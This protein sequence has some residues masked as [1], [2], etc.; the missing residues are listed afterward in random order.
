MKT[1]KNMTFTLLVFCAMLIA[2]AAQ[3]PSPQVNLI[4]EREGIRFDRSGAA[5]GWQLEV[6]N[7]TGELVFASGVMRTPSLTWTL[8]DQQGQALASGLYSYRLRMQ[9]ETGDVLATQTGNVMVN[10]A[11]ENDRIW[12]T[13]NRKAGVGAQDAT[14]LTVISADE[15]ALGGAQLARETVTSRKT[16]TNRTTQDSKSSGVAVPEAVGP[17]SGEGTIGRIARF[18]GANAIGDSAIT[19]SGGNIRINTNVTQGKLSVVNADS[20]AIHGQSTNSFGI[21]GNSTTSIGVRGQSNSGQ[22]VYGFSSSNAGVQG[23]STSGVGVDGSSNSESGVR[24]ISVT[25]YGVEGSSTSDAGVRGTSNTSTGVRG[26]STG[27][28]G[29]W[30]TSQDGTGVR[31]TTLSQSQSEYGVYGLNNG[32]GTAILGEAQN[33]TGI[34]GMTNSQM[35]GNPGVRGIN[36]GVSSGVVG[37]AQS[38]NGTAGISVSGNGVFGQTSRAGGVAGVFGSSLDANGTGVIGRANGNASSGAAEGVRG[39]STY[40]VGVA[41]HGNTG[42]VG[43]GVLG[44]GIVGN[45]TIAGQFNG[46][47]NITGNTDVGGI[48]SKGGGAFKIDHPLD[49]A[50]KYLYHSFVESPDMMNIYN[51]TITTDETGVATVTMPEYFSALN[52]DF[53]YQLT[54]IGQFAQ[55]IVAEKIADNRFTIKTDKPNVEVSWQVTGVR[56]DEF[57]NKH[58]IPNE[59]EKPVAE[60]GYYLHPEAFGQPAEKSVGWARDPQLM[61]KL[62]VER[63]AIEKQQAERQKQQ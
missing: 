22:G 59:V 50:N 30:G 11:S 4:I 7:Q 13:T 34:I 3:A 53:R 48:L 58:R 27:G 31:G 17:I 28:R 54:V 10:R 39:E 37:E 43:S 47:V 9:T 38:G 61:K 57:A 46:R 2:A 1:L 60:R 5:N 29:V 12:I 51:G 36:N 23:I 19:E 55:A 52:R 25:S 49:P 14:D 8:Q 15:S 42:V 16:D 18:T 62:Q 45:G 56:Q 21:R 32:A 41:G 24:G 26:T 40:G 35:P 6:F 63:E 33:G 20:V 44:P